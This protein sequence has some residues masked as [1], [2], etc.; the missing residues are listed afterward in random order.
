MAGQMLYQNACNFLDVKSIENDQQAIAN[1]R[2]VKH[3]Q[4][5][6]RYIRAIHKIDPA[7][8]KRIPVWA[9]SLAVEDC[10]TIEQFL[11]NYRLPEHFEL[12]D[13][14]AR[15]RARYAARTEL[16]VKGFIS[17]NPKYSRTGTTVV[18]IPK[19]S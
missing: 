12:G 5:V 11:L 4:K 3:E 8:V 16:E 9:Q 14:E 6:D 18:F 2:Q 13:E 19:V 7:R 10:E 15:E 1:D 17:L